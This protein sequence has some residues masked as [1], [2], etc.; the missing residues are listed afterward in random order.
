MGS[1]MNKNEFEKLEDSAKIRF[2]NSAIIVLFKDLD[3]YK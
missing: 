2:N 1:V 3:F